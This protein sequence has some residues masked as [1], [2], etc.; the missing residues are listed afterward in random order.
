MIIDTQSNESMKKDVAKLFNIKVK[1]LEDQLKETYR[2]SNIT[3]YFDSN[4]LESELNI[5]LNKYKEEIKKLD[6]IY[7][8]HLTR[9]IP[10]DI[11]KLQSLDEV[12]LSKNYLTD[13]LDKYEITFQKNGDAIDLYYK[14]DNYQNKLESNIHNYNKRE[15][16]LTLKK[17]LGQSSIVDKSINGFCVSPEYTKSTGYNSSLRDGPEILKSLSKLF[18]IPDLIKEFNEETK[19]CCVKIKV[20]LDEI[21]FEN[22]FDYDINEKRNFFVKT[23]LEALLSSLIDNFSF[24]KG[25][26][27]CVRFDDDRRNVKI[28]N[29]TI[30]EQDV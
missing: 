15:T 13:I 20:K 14:G 12:L 18:D 25:Y 21:T 4:F 28:D 29:I 19:Y 27:T 2:L 23:I 5:Y 6:E 26:S 7:I 1:E 10:N 3:G 16:C 11:E 8:Y 9:T 17:R 22:G 24:N 30:M